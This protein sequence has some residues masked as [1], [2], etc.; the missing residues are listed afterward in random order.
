MSLIPPTPFTDSESGNQETKK[1]G[2]REL[3][4]SW[5]PDQKLRSA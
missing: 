3:L 2:V 5:L 1:M 4:G